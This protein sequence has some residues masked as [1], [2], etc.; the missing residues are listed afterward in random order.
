[1]YQKRMS[2]EQSA[3]AYGN[4]DF[5]SYSKMA[6]KGGMYAPPV[7]GPLSSGQ[8][9]PATS[10]G[11]GQHYHALG[12]N[13]GG[14]DLLSTTWPRAN[15]YSGMKTS[16]KISADSKTLAGMCVFACVC[17]CVHR[18]HI[19]G[20]I[21]SWIK[22]QGIKFIKVFVGITWNESLTMLLLCP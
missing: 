8:A 16:R 20:V 7:Q 17:V 11:W 10:R 6:E 22:L 5:G 9:L 19:P 14:S 1:M 13:K 3:P 2:K 12:G 15:G 21:L 18:D 4:T